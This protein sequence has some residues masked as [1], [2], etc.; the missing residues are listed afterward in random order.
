VQVFGDGK[1]GGVHLYEREC[2]LQRRHQKVWEEAPA[3]NLPESIREGLYASAL[4]LV[5]KTRYRSAGTIEFLVEVQPD[6]TMKDYFFIEM[7]TRLQ[8][9]HPVTEAV[10]GID[11]VHEQIKLGLDQANYVLPVVGGPRGH[12]IEVRVC[13]EDP[14]QGF[15]PCTGTIDHLIWP[16]GPGIRVD[17]GIEVGQALGTNFDSMCAKLIAH[18]PDRALAVKRIQYM[19]RETVISGVGTNLDYLAAIAHA[20]PVIEGK[21]STWFLDR[22]FKDAAPQVTPD[23]LSLLA[24]AEE[25]GIPAA[26][27]G[28]GGASARS[29]GTG[30]ATE[31][32]SRNPL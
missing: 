30:S 18:A 28:P 6:G 24:L 12:A 26:G 27:A 23:V 32:W 10:T 8:V 17:R 11:L 3:P 4:K 22:E 14:S 5:E 2:S 21:V 15:I 13:A 31:L 16:S 1:G 25:C 19:L 7:N 9:E 29:Q 20:K